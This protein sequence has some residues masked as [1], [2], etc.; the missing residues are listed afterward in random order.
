MSPTNRENY[1]RNASLQGHAWI[2][3]TVSFSSAYWHEQR[4]ALEEI[5]LRHPML[6][7]DAR[8][9]EIDYDHGIRDHQYHKVDA[10]D[11]EWI[12]PI[13]GLDGQVIGHP[14]ADWDNL[15]T[16]QAPEPAVSDE[17]LAAL[18]ETRAKG[19]LATL[20][21]EHGFLFMRSFYLRGFDNMMLDV[22]TQDPRLTKLIDIIAGY[23]ERYVKPFVRAGLDLLVAGDDLGTQTASILGPK[24]FRQLLLPA[25]RR[26]FVPARMFGAHVY[27]HHDGYVM[28]IIDDVILSGVSI[29]NPQDLVNGI[30]NIARAIKGRV[31]I[32]IDIDRQS[33]MPY[34][35]PQDVRDL[36]KEEVVKLGSPQGGLSMIC[37]VYPPTPLANV[38]ALCSALEEYRTYW[39]GR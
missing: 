13:P 37:G 4:E 33:V 1:I 2:P 36:I 35:S 28:D 32:E 31:C 10:W 9:G 38:E 16:W 7:P 6:F 11:C 22:A 30:D 12:Y 25:Y 18:A 17:R 27:L 39:V 3:Q 19:E 14:L 15:Q 34:G 29:V 20:S 24:H 23:W 8:R 5:V 21:L 26:V